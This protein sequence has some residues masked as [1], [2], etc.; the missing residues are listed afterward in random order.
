MR[1]VGLCDVNSSLRAF[2]WQRALRTLRRFVRLRVRRV[3]HRLMLMGAAVDLQFLYNPN[4]T[5]KILTIVANMKET[6]K[7]LSIKVTESSG[8][9]RGEVF[10]VISRQNVK[11]RQGSKS[12]RKR[13]RG[14][15]R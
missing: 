1:R 7:R 2:G 8:K 9:N 11:V 15:I 12:V 6:A 10:V 4:E 13:E 14:K 3:G 5:Q